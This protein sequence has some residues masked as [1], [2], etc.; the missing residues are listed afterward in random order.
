MT[1]ALSA[2]LVGTILIGTA[3]VGETYWARTFVCTLIIPFGMDMSFPAATL[4]MSNS[5]DKKHQ[6]VAAS[7]VNTIVN[8]S[9]SLALGFA[10]TVEAY[11]ADGG[12]TGADRL[13]GIRHAFYMAYGLAAGGLLLSIMFMAK[14]FLF[15]RKT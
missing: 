9:I 12:L 5:V 10:G 3:P 14:C 4:I 6:G 2:F 13:A 1:I 7:L 11:T 15:I 8:Y